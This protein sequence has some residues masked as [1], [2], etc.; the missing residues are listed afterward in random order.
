MDIPRLRTT[1][2]VSGEGK[3]GLFVATFWWSLS[4]H[5]PSTVNDS[6]IH[7][8][9]LLENTLLHAVETVGC[10]KDSKYTVIGVWVATSIGLLACSLV[11]GIVDSWYLI[12]GTEICLA[13][14]FEAKHV[15]WAAQ[16]KCSSVHMV[17]HLCKSIQAI[18]CCHTDLPQVS[19]HLRQSV[20]LVIFPK[21]IRSYW[22]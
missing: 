13:R 19:L 22:E 3:L 20:P 11:S 17:L 7:F 5:S 16:E 12:P 14:A 6:H 10:D 8:H 15:G 18:Q 21:T 9:L 2:G 4:H 1:E